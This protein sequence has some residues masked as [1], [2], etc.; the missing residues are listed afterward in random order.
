MKFAE[1]QMPWESFEK[2]LPICQL[3]SHISFHTDHEIVKWRVIFCEHNSL[4]FH[5]LWSPKHAC[6][7]SKVSSHS[8]EAMIDYCI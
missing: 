6:H 1:N 2:S 4:I 8:S 5:T 3:I 7:S